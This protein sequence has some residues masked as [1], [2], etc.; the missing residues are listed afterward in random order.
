MF[1]QRPLSSIVM[2]KIEEMI[3]GS[4]RAQVTR[5][6]AK[7]ACGLERYYL[8]HKVYPENLEQVVPEFLGEMPTDPIT[9]DFYRYARDAAGRYKIWSL[10]WNEEDNGGVAGPKGDYDDTG[11]WVW[12]YP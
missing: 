3:R 1:R 8:K 6:Q 5:D 2:P 10:G 9:G 7:L 4:C 12:Q 11:D